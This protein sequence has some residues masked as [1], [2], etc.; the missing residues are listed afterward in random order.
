L[1]IRC[2]AVAAVTVREARVEGRE[3][4]LFRKSV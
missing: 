4:I 1:S 2:F 3:A